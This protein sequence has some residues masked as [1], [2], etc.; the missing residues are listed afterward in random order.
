MMKEPEIQRLY[1]VR[2]KSA[3]PKLMLVRRLMWSFVQATLYRWSFHTFNRWRAMLL[4]LFGAKIG[5]GCLLRRTSTVYYP[6][7]LEMGSVCCLGDMAQIYNLGKVTLGDR[8]TISQEAYICAGSHDY[9]DLTMPLLTP[10]VV[11][12]DDCWI[13]ARAFVGPGVTIG[14][15]AIVGAVAVAMRDVPDWTIVAGNP[16]KFIKVREKPR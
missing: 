1:V 7:L 15:G 11:L 13:C 3:A 5:H 2:L 14:E 12:K 6:W 4:R 16:A 8:V 9:T 10:P